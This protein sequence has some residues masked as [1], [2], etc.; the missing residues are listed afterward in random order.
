MLGP[1]NFWK[2]T[3]P[4]TIYLKNTCV[5]STVRDSQNVPVYSLALKDL[6]LQ[7]FLYGLVRSAEKY[8]NLSLHIYVVKI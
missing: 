3:C 5:T 1:G 7:E 8:G 6:S 2:A 4:A